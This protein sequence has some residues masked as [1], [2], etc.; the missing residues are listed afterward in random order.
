ME[1]W[2]LEIEEWWRREGGK[3]KRGREDRKEGKGEE[4][5][6]KKEGK[7]GR[8]ERKKGKGRRGSCV[9]SWGFGGVGG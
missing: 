4:R 5:K 2:A 1:R 6:G 8:E 7:R 3:G 9:A